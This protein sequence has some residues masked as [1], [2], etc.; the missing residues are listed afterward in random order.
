MI[1]GELRYEEKYLINTS[2]WMVLRHHLNEVLP[3]DSHVLEDGTYHIISAYLENDFN[4]YYLTKEAGSLKRHF[5]RLR[6]YNSMASGIILEAKGRENDFVYKHQV[7]LTVEDYHAIQEGNYD[8]L[9]SKGEW[10][11][12]MYASMALNHPLPK[13]VIS[14]EREALYVP[15]LDIR[16][17]VDREVRTS[18]G[19][20][21]DQEG[22]IPLYE[23]DE[24]I[25]E[26]KG[27]KR[28]PRYLSSLIEA[29]HP[30]RILNSKL[31]VAM[32]KLG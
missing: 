22:L 29:Y 19:N 7:P 14:Y 20:S 2:Q 5:L 6:T 11:E 24:L 31:E 3:H 13:I 12:Q 10:G 27:K 16:I 4:S 32:M 9:L 21:L 23:P 28:L 26:I 15:N 8:C 30:I 25:L 1:P 17:T 18:W